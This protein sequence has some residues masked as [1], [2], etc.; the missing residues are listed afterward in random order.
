MR[1]IKFVL[2]CLAVNSLLLIPPAFAQTSDSSTNSVKILF[3]DQVEPGQKPSDVPVFQ[4]RPNSLL[5]HP[6]FNSPLPNKNLARI[7]MNPPSDS[8][9]QAGA[10]T[11][12]IP[13]A[14]RMGFVETNEKYGGILRAGFVS[15]AQD[16]QDHAPIPP[17]AYQASEISS[18]GSEPP[19]TIQST[20]FGTSLPSPNAVPLLQEPQLQENSEILF[21]ESRELKSPEGNKGLQLNAPPRDFSAS[22]IPAQLPRPGGIQERRSPPPAAVPGNIPIN[23]PVPQNA[24][25]NPS[26]RAEALLDSVRNPAKSAVPANSASTNLS[27]PPIPKNSVPTLASPNSGSPSGNPIGT[28]QPYNPFSRTQ[29]D[30]LNMG[31]TINFSSPPEPTVSRQIS[32]TQS[33]PSSSRNGNAPPPPPS[34]R[35]TDAPPSRS[36]ITDEPPLEIGEN[37]AE[38]S[39]EFAQFDRQKQTSFFCSD[40]FYINIFA[41]NNSA[42]EFDFDSIVNS[43]AAGFQLKDGVAIGSAIGIYHGR[44][45]R[46]EYEFAYRTNAVESFQ[47][48]RGPGFANQTAG[49]DGDLNVFTGMSNAYWDFVDLKFPFLEP[50]VGAGIGFAHFDADFNNFG[51]PVLD[52]HYDSDSN[53]AYQW[54][55]GGTRALTKDIDFFV[56]YRYVNSGNVDLRYDLQ[57]MNLSP[58]TD[59]NGRFDYISKNILFGVKIRF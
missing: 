3:S 50:Y 6:A 25:A 44:N 56:E 47:Y 13:R 23:Q 4:P 37:W 17:Q 12:E 15:P 14:D 42:N 53:F 9:S 54:M 1:L 28:A 33:S 8:A 20:A 22:D 16:T 46:A 52:G 32:Q 48:S 36:F 59:E 10:G 55:V 35:L 29:T 49:I 38:P 40:L 34:T 31:E 27:D 57:S 41:G 58:F 45:L 43:P 21:S 5:Q 26:S 11:Q 30:L 24:V 19:R 2:C 39:L 51:R 7:R 18:F